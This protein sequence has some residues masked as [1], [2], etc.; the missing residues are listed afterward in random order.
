M[1]HMFV[2]IGWDYINTFSLLSDEDFVSVLKFIAFYE[3]NKR[4]IL[5]IN[6]TYTFACFLSW[7]FNL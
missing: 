3:C 2:D 5:L 1:Y 6:Y 7:Y 4:R